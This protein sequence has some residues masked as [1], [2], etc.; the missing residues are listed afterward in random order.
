MSKQLFQIIVHWTKKTKW[1]L[2]AFCPM[3]LF[4]D[5]QALKK[6][7]YGVPAWY[8][9]APHH[10]GRLLKVHGKNAFFCF[11]LVKGER[12]L[13][14]VFVSF[15]VGSFFLG[16]LRCR[17][18]FIAWKCVSFGILKEI[19]VSCDCHWHWLSA[20]CRPHSSPSPQPREVGPDISRPLQVM[21]CVFFVAENPVPASPKKIRLPQ[22]S[23]LVF[24]FLA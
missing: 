4:H 7:L 1:G 13:Y 12:H 11:V 14:F 17:G 23:G 16:I 24:F 8:S 10:F 15:L 5:P 3:G 21:R 6:K 22:V 20:S 19:T 9:I 18:I 2:R